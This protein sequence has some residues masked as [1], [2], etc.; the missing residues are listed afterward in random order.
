MRAS[1]CSTAAVTWSRFLASS[2]WRFWRFWRRRISA[3][4]A[5][6]SRAADHL[7]GEA[8]LR[9]RREQ[10]KKAAAYEARPDVFISS[11][12][13]MVWGILGLPDPA[14]D[15]A[16]I[17]GVRDKSRFRRS[18]KVRQEGTRPTLVVEV[19]SDEPEHQSADHHDKVAIYERAGVS[20]YL[21]L[22]PPTPLGEACRWTGYR[23][24]VAG[25]YEPIPP[26]AEGCLL[27][28]ATGLRFGV[29][30]DGTSFQLMDAT[31]GELL[32]SS[33]EG[34]R[35]AE[36]ELIRLRAEIDRLRGL[37]ETR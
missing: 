25:R 16:V 6:S 30:P 18:F 13:K 11:D 35:K 34:R 17:P 21:I 33:A 36:A 1:A 23:L 24:N 26:D 3:G 5:A 8:V 12:L 15:V 22:D 32:L 9:M 27:S 4:S 7:D 29:A 37:S 31:T 28:A 14:P 2:F 19:V 10:K 20:E